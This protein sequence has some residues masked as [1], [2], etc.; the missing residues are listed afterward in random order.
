MTND[1][2]PEILEQHPGVFSGVN[3]YTIPLF[4]PGT[5]WL[6]REFPTQVRLGVV[7][8]VLLAPPLFIALNEVRAWLGE[9]L[10]A[11]VG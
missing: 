6:A 7:G 10:R 5:R 8:L 3:W 11:L 4:D 9:M 1:P 2:P